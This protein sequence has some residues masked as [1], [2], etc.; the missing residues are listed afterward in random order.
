MV[1]QHIPAYHVDC[2]TVQRPNEYTMLIEK[3]YWGWRDDELNERS[4][5]AAH[6]K[7]ENEN[8]EFGHVI[9]SPHKYGNFQ[10]HVKYLQYT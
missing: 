1:A 5:A 6:K 7:W 2:T 8:V 9:M 4:D 3:G 10:Q